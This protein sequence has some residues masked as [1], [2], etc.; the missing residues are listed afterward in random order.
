[1]R[2][3]E[4]V[5]E[6][7]CHGLVFHVAGHLCLLHASLSCTWPQSHS[8]WSTPGGRAAVSATWCFALHTLPGGVVPL[9]STL[10]KCHA[11]AGLHFPSLLVTVTNE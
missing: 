9:Q 8:L 1:M 4:K 7:S 11:R 5:R 3:G 6:L 2:G 10:I